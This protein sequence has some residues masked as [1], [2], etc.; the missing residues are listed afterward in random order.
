MDSEFYREGEIKMK[1][2]FFTKKIH[3]TSFEYELLYCSV[4]LNNFL[5]QKKPT[6]IVLTAFL[7][8]T[9]AVRRGCE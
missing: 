3:L 7:I 9:L 6:S 8:L 5:Y 1:T 2:H 4:Q